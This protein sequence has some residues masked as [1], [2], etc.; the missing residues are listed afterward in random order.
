T[1]VATGA[2]ESGY[3]SERNDNPGSFTFP[4]LPD[5]EYDVAA[6]A[7]LYSKGHE[8]ASRTS[9]V[10]VKGADVD[11]VMLEPIAFAS[12]SG[13]VVIDSTA[14]QNQ[15]QD[16]QTTR[17][18]LIE[19]AA[20]VFRRVQQTI[21][22]RD[23]ERPYAGAL[24][25]AVDSKGNFTAPKLEPGAY[26]L[27]ADL[28]GDIWYVSSIT[29]PGPGSRPAPTSTIFSIKDGEHISGL[30]ISLRPGAASLHGKIAW[31][32]DSTTPI[33]ALRVHLVPLDPAQADNPLRFAETVAK[34]GGALT[35]PHIAPGRYRL[36]AR[37]AIES[38]DRPLAETKQGRALLHRAAQQ[39][40]VEI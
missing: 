16:C 25:V 14:E 37:P 23:F 22:P 3:L 31:A 10:T 2:T 40:G 34:P 20:L 21:G 5:G 1:N 12:I 26:R 11:G 15:K 13:R 9:R 36:L 24:D 27:R 28:P 33:Q 32:T 19:E 4:N 29:A 18:A 7:D 6:I 8:A 39:N 38:P 35:I 30:T 17:A